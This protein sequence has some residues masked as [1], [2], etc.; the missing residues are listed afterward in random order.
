MTILLWPIIFT[1]IRIN[2]Q[3]TVCA[4]Q[5]LDQNVE[6]AI[7]LLYDLTIII[8]P[9]FECNKTLAAADGCCC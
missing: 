3:E 2:A 7:I 9:L 6:E 8:A 5:I 4:G 1:V